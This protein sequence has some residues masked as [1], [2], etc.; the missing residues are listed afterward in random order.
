M[1]SERARERR[2]QADPGAGDHPRSTRE[3]VDVEVEPLARDRDDQAEADD[4]LGGGDGHHGEREDLAVV[5]AVQARERD[6][7]EVRRR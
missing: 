2:E 7:G 6:Q 4:D 1:I 5:V 3:P